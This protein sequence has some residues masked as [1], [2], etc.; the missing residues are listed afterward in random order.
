MGKKKRVFAAA[1]AAALLFTMPGM[2]SYAEAEDART[3]ENFESVTVLAEDDAAQETAAETEAV[4]EPEAE[5]SDT[6]QPKAGEDDTKDAE[7]DEKEPAEDETVPAQKEDAGECTCGALCTQDSI[8][9]DCPVCGGEDADLSRCKGEKEENITEEK[10]EDAGQEDTGA[11]D[12]SANLCAHHKEHTKDCGYS[13]VSEDGE[14][15][16]CTY[17]CRICPIE[18]LIAA[19]PHRVTADNAETV[20]WQLDEILALYTELSKDE[21]E[22]IDLSPCWDLQAALDEANAPVTIDEPTEGAV[23]QVEIAGNITY[24][25]TIEEAWTAANGNTATITLLDDVT[26]NDTLTVDNASTITFEG[27]DHTLTSGQKTAIEVNGTL[28]LVSGAIHSTY[29]NL[30]ATGIDVNGTLEMTGG[31]VS[32]S[33]RVTSGSMAVHTN[34]NSNITISGGKISGMYG[35]YVNGGTVTIQKGEISVNYFALYILS[36][37]VTIEGG[38]FTGSNFCGMNIESGTVVLRGGTFTG[39]DNAIGTPNSVASLL[40]KSKP[41]VYFDANGQCTCQQKLDTNFKIFY[42]LFDF[43]TMTM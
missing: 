12:D 21:Q 11:Q 17:E 31:T 23:A 2:A 14:G 32:T 3:E 25:S 36:G 42:S 34:S 33:S 13:L 37:T 10:K 40:D 24:H 9:G 27:G 16:P 43:W 4:Q 39:G 18:G 15:N 22:Q 30:D 41:Y 20:R 28:K 1:L 8:N 19:L 38:T 26:A 7:T 29:S 6:D 35:V 5:D